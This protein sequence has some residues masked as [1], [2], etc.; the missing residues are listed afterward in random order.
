MRSLDADQPRRWWVVWMPALLAAWGAWMFASRVPVFEVTDRG[1]LEVQAAAHT[2]SALSAGRIVSSQLQLGRHVTAGEV[3]VEL[4]SEPA[5]LALKEKLSRVAADQSR[6]AGLEREIASEQQTR[7]AMQQA[8]VRANEESDAQIAKAESQ[9]KFARA[10]LERS[11]KLRITG[12]AS[13][14]D[15]DRAHLAVDTG[16]AALTEARAS[17]QRNEQDRRAIESEQETRIVRLE[18][19]AAEI[20]GDIL[21]EQAAIRRLEREIAECRLTAPV[22]GRIGDVANVRV[23]T[24][25]KTAEPLCSI[26]PPGTPRAIAWFPTVVVGRIKPGQAARLRLAGFPWTQYGVVAARVSDVGTEPRD[27]FILVELALEPSPTSVI[28]L[29]HGLTGSVEIEVERVSPVVLALR[30]AGQFLGT[31]RESVPSVASEPQRTSPSRP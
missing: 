25:V 6:R 12:A 30:A 29:E 4:D 9:V 28:P 31:R 14:A 13:Q 20:E 8:R 22:S 3:L 18:R 2:L 5:Q 7:D 1:R 15:V 21:V 27:G 16:Q 19:E 23:G 11:T 24:V 10:D 26:V 17:R